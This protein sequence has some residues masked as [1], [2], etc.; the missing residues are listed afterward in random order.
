MSTIQRVSKLITLMVTCLGSFMVLLDA[1]I[2]VTALPTIQ[3][4]FHA[5]LLD[6]Q[7]VVDAFT[8]AFA[9]LMLTGGTLGDRFGRKRFFLL[10]LVLFLLGSTFCGFA[11]TLD[12]LLFGRVIQGMGAAALAPGSLSVLASAFPEPRERTRAIGI[13]AS[14][15]GLGLAI[16]PLA[17]GWLIGIANWPAIFFVN[18]PVGLLTLVL[19]I[20]KLSESRNPHARRI[21]LPGQVL[22]TGT[23]FCLVM[24]LIEGSSAGWTSPLIL[25]LFIGSTVCLLAFLFVEARVPEPMV[26]LRLFANR[27]FSVANVA[28]VVLGF[29]MMGALFFLVQFLQNVQGYSAFETG[30][31]TLPASV[32]IF[33]I[34][35]FVGRLTARIGP[36]LPIIL[37]A[38]LGATALFLLAT[39]LQSDTSY[40]T[41]GWQIALFGIG[42]GFMMTPLTAA[43]LSATPKERSGLGSSLLNTGRQVGITLGVAVLGA[44]V[45]QQYPGNIVSQLTQRSLP[46]SVSATIAEK[47]ATAS[48]GISQGPQSEHLPLP[49]AVLQQATR[50]AFVNTLHGAFLIAAI[51]LFAVAL[52]VAFLLQAAQ[53]ATRTRAAS[54]DSHEVTEVL[55]TQSIVDMEITK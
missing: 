9:A 18:L 39:T 4:H 33:A 27:V 25:G 36:R 26:P 16:G 6:L 46:A 29:A 34:A 31:R 53:P 13:W 54:V 17:G 7:W 40:S 19:S 38:L 22:V 49:T 50:Q 23:L 15:S 8:L 37:G 41:L 10:G 44:F 11:P 30:L 5:T 28:S 55:T 12:W 20:L 48:A 35:P 32:G 45:L 43:V 1:S 47:I 2:V 42:C 3:N 51:G 14:I 24:A 21:D 52:L